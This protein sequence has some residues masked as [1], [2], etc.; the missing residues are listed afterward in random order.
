MSTIHMRP[1]FDLVVDR[2]ADEAMERL[3]ERL[4]RPECG[5]R[6]DV[7]DYQIEIRITD[8]HHHYWSPELN[9]LIDRQDDSKARLHG[10]FGPGAHVWTLFMAGYAAFG[11]VGAAGL[12]I[13]FSQW[14][15]GGDLWGVWF[16]LAGVVG[17]ALVYF[18]SR[19]GQ[20]LAAPQM[21][22]IRKLIYDAFPDDVDDDERERVT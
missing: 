10:K 16:I 7:Y 21:R 11:M 4:K 20:R 9:L 1:R 13:V 8:P 18:G 14:T 17:C 5:C 12:L 22:D 2:S 19:I 6:A 15:L 3:Q